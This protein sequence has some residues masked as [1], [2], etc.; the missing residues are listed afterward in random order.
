MNYWELRSLVSKVIPRR[1]Q[2]LPIRDRVSAV[3]EKGRKSNYHQFSITKGE[4]VKH[5]RLLNTEEVSSFLEISIRAAA[6]PMPFNIDVWDGLLCPYA[7]KYCFADAFRASLYTAFFDNS[8]TMG[9][10]HCNPTFYKKE[11]DSLMSLRGKD[12]HTITNDVKKAIALEIPMRMGIRFEDFSPS[13]RKKGISLQMLQYLADVSYPIMINTKSDLIGTEPYVKALADNEAGSAVH[14]TMISSSE[15]ILKRI[16]P[17]APSFAKRIQGAKNLIDAGVRVVA[18]IEPYLV[19]ITDEKEQVEDYMDQCWNAGIRHIT[20]DTYS[21]SANNPGIRASFIREGYDFERMFTL[22]CDSQALGSLLLDKFMDLFRDRGFS[23]S[24]FDV[25]CAPTNNQT[26]CCEV[27]DLF[28]GGFNYGSIV[29]AARQIIERGMTPTRWSDFEEYVNKNG[30]FLSDRLRQDVHRLWNIQGNNAYA[31]NWA[32]GIE[33][34]GRDE[35]GIIWV[36][37]SG[38]DHREEILNGII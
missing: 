34:H 7:C 32:A 28:K 38:F 13:E 17:G 16:E 19:F 11:L 37:D 4:F 10:R 25:G 35:H 33:P 30:G 36:Y 15:S 21:Y 18:R 24:T 3:K 8:K 5:E 31:V 2:L 12:P 26:V 1:T 9:I 27:G 6:C 20:F 23:C 29:V 14:I 22:G